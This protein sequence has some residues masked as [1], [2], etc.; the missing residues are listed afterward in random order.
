[1]FLSTA[2]G[3]MDG[4]TPKE[5]IHHIGHSLQR[6]LLHSALEGLYRSDH[7]ETERFVCVGT[8]LL[9]H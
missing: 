2:A 5:P 9:G 7:D 6:S 8:G 1:M 3:L 4:V